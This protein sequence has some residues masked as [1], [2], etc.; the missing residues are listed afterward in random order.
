MAPDALTQYYSRRAPHYEE[1]WRRNDPVRHSEQLAI[2]NEI[3]RLFRGRRVLEIACGS[4]YWT[5]F[6][7]ETASS[8]CAID[9][10]EEMLALARAKDLRADRVEFRRAD[11]HALDA[12]AGE[13]DASLANFWFSHVPKAR[14]PQF[15]ADLN[16]RLCAGALVFMADNVFVDGLGGELLRPNDS[17]DTFKLRTLPDGSTERVLKNYFDETE[18]RT[19]FSDFADGLTI[20]YGT[21]F[22]SVSYRTLQQRGT[23]S[24]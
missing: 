17:A 24:V 21:C 14:I 7:A 4:G 9:T 23:S 16:R 1:I 19:L 3:R 18:L 12:L 22:W 10:S 5:Q 13:F 8:V 11:A 2:V 6:A 20:T 15:L